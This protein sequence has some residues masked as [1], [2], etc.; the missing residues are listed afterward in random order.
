M[1]QRRFYRLILCLAFCCSLFFALSVQGATE[2][3]GTV[4]VGLTIPSSSSGGGGG[5]STGGSPSPSPTPTPTPTPTDTPPTISNVVADVSFTTVTV[6]WSATDDTQVSSASFVYGLS[7]D[8]GS[9]GTVTGS[10]TTTLSGLAAN[11]TY[12]YQISAT[13]SAGLTTTQTGT[14]VTGSAPDTTPPVITNVAASAGLTSAAISWTTD[15]LANSGLNY[16]LTASYGS[17]I[18]SDANYV[19]SHSVSLAGLISN[20]TYYY[21][22]IT[23][24]QS[25]NTA[26]QAGTFKTAADTTPPA[27]VSNLTITVGAS[28]I[29]LQWSNPS[30]SDFAGVKVIRKIGGPSANISDGTLLY[31]GTGQ[32]FSDSPPSTGTLYYYTIFSFDTSGNYSGGVFKSGEIAAPPVAEICNNGIDD[33]GNGLIDCADPACFGFSGC[34]TVTPPVV[35]LQPYQPP[36]STVPSFAEV[37]LADL[38]FLAGNRHIR[39]TLSDGRVTDLAGATL[40]IML[41]NSALA[42]PASSLIVNVDGGDTHQFVYNSETDSYYADITMPPIGRHTAF[43]EIDYG[44]GQLDTIPVP[45]VSL[46]QG[47]ITANRASLSEATVSLFTET[48]QKIVTDNWGAPNPYITNANGIYAWVVPNG[49][50]YLMAAKNKYYTRVTQPFLVDNNIVN[51]DLELVHQPPDL[52]QDITPTSTLPDIV[53]TVGKNIAARTRAAVQLG[54]QKIVDVKAAVDNFKSNVAVQETAATVVAPAVVSVAAIST[55]SLI[56]WANL[57]PF[58]RFLFLQPLMLLGLR[59]RK[60]WGQVYNSLNK[61]P[62]DLTTV[63]LVNYETGR[64]VQSRVTDSKGRYAFIASPGKYRIEAV[65]RNFLFPSQLLAGFKDDGRRPDVYHGEIIEV[66][67]KDAVITANIPLDP[68]GE[69]KRPVRF[70][71]QQFWRRVQLILSW[72]G[73]IITAASL[74]IS[75]RWYVWALLGIHILLFIIF[76]RLAVPPKVKSWGIVYDG[77]SKKPIGRA[78]ARLF[79]SQFN[80]LVST[81]ITDG[82]GRYYF[83]A[84]DNK[85]YVTYDHPDYSSGKTDLINLSG[86]EAENIAVDVGLK[87]PPIAPLE[88]EKK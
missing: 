5:G 49:Q 47:K 57:V 16:G 60:G 15:E 78:V 87:K 26:N 21:Q 56:S 43:V 24:D 9:T 46:A 19:L 38:H 79:N 10:Y 39:L 81:Q 33:D 83:L 44:A 31:T 84:G 68:V 65:K 85:Y 36:A 80:K 72:L 12:F 41:P 64:V 28:A 3:N 42:A 53:K 61:L 88:E 4:T 75:P 77:T 1:K 50:Y 86:K 52:L 8:Y 73:I 45:L 63:R 20:T 27:D 82:R 13:D 2:S 18:A 74:Y 37:T 25:G 54:I 32:S 6:S 58:L 59:R 7:T 30:D 40:S 71:W 17:T 14:F 70:F 23:A 67:E 48:G 69:H 55:V 34:A 11:S 51:V 76:R 66:S 29:Q 22:I 62:V 35:P